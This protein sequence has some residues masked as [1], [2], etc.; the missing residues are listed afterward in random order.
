MT[1]NQIDVEIK[2][3][4]VLSDTE[5]HDMAVADWYGILETLWTAIGKPVEKKRMLIYGKDLGNVPCELL[6]RA[7]KRIRLNSIYSQVPTIG[8]IWQAVKME[9]AEDNCTTSE[10]WIERKWIYFMGRARYPEVVHE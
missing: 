2:K 10:E 1:D 7:I 3:Y 9:L 6:E 5:I 8:E 4:P